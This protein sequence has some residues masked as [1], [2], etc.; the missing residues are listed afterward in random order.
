MGLP[1]THLVKMPRNRR[2][3]GITSTHFLFVLLYSHLVLAKVFLNL[4]IESSFGCIYTSYGAIF[5]L[6]LIFEKR[7]TKNEIGIRKMRGGKAVEL[8]FARA[9]TKVSFAFFVL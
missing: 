5:I 6:I 9:F 1:L 3:M 4:D 2:I 8:L 7:P